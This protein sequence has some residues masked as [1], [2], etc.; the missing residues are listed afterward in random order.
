MKEEKPDPGIGWSQKG[1]EPR[2]EI[3]EHIDSGAQNEAGGQKDWEALGMRYPGTGKFTAQ[4]RLVF[5][6][7][8]DFF[9]VNE[10]NRCL[11]LKC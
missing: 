3:K 5:E 6:G 2:T 9:W 10:K 8:N 11:C 4:G 1:L 7:S